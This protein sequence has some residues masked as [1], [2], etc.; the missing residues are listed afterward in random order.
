MRLY[1]TTGG[2]QTKW[3]GSQADASKR[4]VELRREGLK[5]VETEEVEVPTNKA[6]LLEF[7]NK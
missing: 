1:K 3:D 7:L 4:R 6:G 2:D 5:P